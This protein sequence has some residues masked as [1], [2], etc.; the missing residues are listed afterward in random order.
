MIKALGVKALAVQANLAMP[1]E[2]EQLF[3]AI[4]A[5]FGRLDVLVNNA[6]T[7]QRCDVLEATVE[8]WNYVMAINLRAPFLCSQRAAHLMLARGTPGVI[9][10]IADVA[11]QVPWTA[12]LITASAR[13]VC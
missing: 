11:G 7:F 3:V 8:E 6:S 2:I 13:R 12:T 10:N 5:T 1:L 9:I 4:E